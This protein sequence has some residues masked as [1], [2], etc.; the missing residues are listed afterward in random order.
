VGIKGSIDE[1]STDEWNNAIGGKRIRFPECQFALDH[2]SP[3]DW[4][5]CQARPRSGHGRAI[6]AE[7]VEAAFI[8]QLPISQGKKTSG[9]C[10]PDAET[11][12]RQARVGLVLA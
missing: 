8:V 7:A 5:E 11:S 6:Y 2:Q 3:N 4:R 10:D 12:C 9:G 1:P